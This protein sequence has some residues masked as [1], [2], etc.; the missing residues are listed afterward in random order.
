M[1][2]LRWSPAETATDFSITVTFDRPIEEPHLYLV[3]VDVYDGT[4]ERIT[5]ANKR[6]GYSDKIGSRFQ[7]IPTSEVSS[8]VHLSDWTSDVYFAEVHVR[9]LPW[10]MKGVEEPPIP[11]SCALAVSS[12]N[13]AHTPRIWEVHSLVDAADQ[14]KTQEVA[15]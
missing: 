14:P 10:N 13:T 7:Y 3:A 5:P 8:V 6:W 12:D 11:L 15:A 9:V 1:K 2:T 4:G